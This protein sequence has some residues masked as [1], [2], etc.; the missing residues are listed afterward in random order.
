MSLTSMLTETSVCKLFKVFIDDL[1]IPID[2]VIHFEWQSTLWLPIQKGNLLLNSN[3]SFTNIKDNNFF[4]KAKEIKI[5]I[6]DNRG[7]YVTKYFR[8][9]NV[10]HVESVIHFTLND[11]VSYELMNTYIN[12]SYTN[13]PKN[14]QLK[15]KNLN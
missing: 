5:Q 10:T 15:N 13:Y 4:N 11:I 6:R 3:Y 14:M 1:E 8:S 9:V 12:A 2:S 7:D